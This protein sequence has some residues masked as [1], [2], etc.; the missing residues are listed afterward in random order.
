MNKQ[1]SG[2]LALLFLSLSLLCSACSNEDKD[3]GP[4]GIW[5]IYPLNV[6]I[7]V[8]DKNE[9]DLLDSDFKHNLLESGIKATHKGTTYELKIDE[10]SKE[11]S[12][13]YYMPTFYGLKLYPF[14]KKNYLSIGEFDGAK[15]YK[16]EKII[17]DW[18]DGTKNTIT[19][20]YKLKWKNNK[21]YAE[22][23]FFLDGVKVKDPIEIIK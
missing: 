4:S 5:D 22:K 13:R 2:Y 3:E 15:E 16:Q 23:E 19:F 18:N 8:Q 7:I 14:D 12:T 17:I 6:L 10:L 21:P 20:N 1:L 9:N 11:P